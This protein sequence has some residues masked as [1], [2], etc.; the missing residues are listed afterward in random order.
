M[1]PWSESLALPRPLRDL[2]LKLPAEEAGAQAQAAAEEQL[3]AQV[4]ARTARG[5]KGPERTTLPAARPKCMS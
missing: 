4:R 2:R 5:G 1:K 3:A